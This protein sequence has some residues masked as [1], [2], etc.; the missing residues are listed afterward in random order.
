MNVLDEFCLEGLNAF[1]EAEQAQGRV[2]H[3]VVVAGH[4]VCL[5]F[6]GPALVPAVMPA[7]AHLQAGPAAEPDIT[8]YLWD[9]ASGGTYPP[10]P[11]FAPDDYRRY[12]QRALLDD[13]QRAVM[14]TPAARVLCAY[15]R[16]ARLGL[17]WTPA[18]EDLSIYERATPLQTML[19]WALNPHGWHI[20]HGGVVGTGAGGV[21]LV[22]NA[23]SGK[24][25]TCLSCLQHT[26]LVYMCDDK[27]LLSC[28]GGPRAF[29]LYDSSKLNADSLARMAHL[30]P[31]IAGC[32]EQ[33]KHGKSLIFLYPSYEHRLVKELPLQAIVIPHVSDRPKPEL[34]PVAASRAFK[35]LGPGTAIW[36]PGS[37]A[38][39]YHFMAHL[40]TRLPC[41][42]LHLCRDLAANAHLIAKLAGSF[43]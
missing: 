2:Q 32:D 25:T 13:G 6:A 29:G 17:F 38:E 3:D 24:S 14:H 23:G 26:D 12:G 33:A 27:C 22:G 9:A 34:E 19:N 4:H 40:V 15:D 28:E 43:V 37:E 11:P 16:P 8:F 42:W 39:N 1:R 7:I 5:R 35:A 21:L 20:A 18:A 10:R 41:Y 31:L 36:L 30:R